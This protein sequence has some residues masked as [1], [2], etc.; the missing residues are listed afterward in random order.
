[1]GAGRGQWQRA[2][3][4]QGADVLAFDD[5]SALPGNGSELSG[6]AGNI[7][8][9]KPMVGGVKRGDERQ[10]S[11]WSIRRSRRTLLC[12]YPEVRHRHV[13]YTVL[14]RATSSTTC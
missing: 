12:V 2:L 7:A 11:S 1:M 14:V 10:L 5:F 9:T 3:S 8:G 4:Q 6:T 13:P